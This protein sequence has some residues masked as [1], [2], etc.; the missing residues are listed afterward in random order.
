M[1]CGQGIRD[2]P[3]RSAAPHL[4]RR[5][6]RVCLPP[7]PLSTATYSLRA[8]AA[9]LSLDALRALPSATPRFLPKKQVPTATLLRSGQR[10]FVAHAG[11][12]ALSRSPASQPLLP[13]PKMSGDRS[14]Q[15]C[16]PR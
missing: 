3:R 16:G 10:T 2:L 12:A 13:I 7:R 6:T 14:N 8:S 15:M 4:C 11:N 1:R 9:L 5:P